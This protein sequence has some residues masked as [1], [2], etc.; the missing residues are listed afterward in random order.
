VQ[1]TECSQCIQTEQTQ[2]ATGLGYFFL[3]VSAVLIL[4]QT[5]MTAVKLD[6]EAHV[7]AKNLAQTVI[8]S[9]TCTA[10]Y[11]MVKYA[12]ALLFWGR[13]NNISSTNGVNLGWNYLSDVI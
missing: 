9:L 12:T 4:Q 3:G 11:I 6:A 1:F 10:E 8:P 2:E 7:Q 13:H 5:Y